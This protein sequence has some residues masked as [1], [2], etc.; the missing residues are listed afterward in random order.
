[1]VSLNTESGSPQ[2]KKERKHI[3]GLLKKKYAAQAP[4]L[5]MPF[6]NRT[7]RVTMKLRRETHKEHHPSKKCPHIYEKYP[8]PEET[9]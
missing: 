7:L 6:L 2:G 8:V 3:Q 1:M 5:T 9:P 4:L